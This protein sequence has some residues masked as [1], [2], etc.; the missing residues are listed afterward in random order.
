[1]TGALVRSTWFR[2]LVTV[3][4]LAW[5]AREISFA[6]AARAIVSLDPR[7]ALIVLGLL[8]LDRAV[9]IWRWL[10]L[11]RATGHTLRAKSAAWIYLVSAFVG[12]F[13]PAGIGSDIARA[14]TLGQRTSQGSDAVASVAIDRMLGMISILIVGAS[15][16]LGWGARYGIDAQQL[17]G[18]AGLLIL[19]GTVALLFADLLARRLIPEGWHEGA[20]GRRALRLADATAQYRGHRRALAL[21]L[22]L[23]IGVQ[24]LRI[25]QAYV[26]GRGIGIDVA[27]AYYLIFMPVALLTLLLP[28]SVAGLGIPQAGIVWLLAREGVPEPA[29]FALS[30]LIVLSGIVANLPGA[31]LYLRER[32]RR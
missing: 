25:G 16:A 5:L 20:I 26:L 3:G 13:T 19:A 15:A 9:M 23:S 2:A 29:G 24:L 32:R 28:I 8:A 6:E 1:V 4:V 10:V 31:W 11:L 27:F 21:V 30:T 17:I 12:G 14:Y 7:A 22:A 18:F